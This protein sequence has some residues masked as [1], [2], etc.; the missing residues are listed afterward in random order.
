VKLSKEQARAAMAPFV[1][2]AFAALQRY[3]LPWLEIRLEA[4][5]SS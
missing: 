2:D 1:D 4:F 3:G 5:H